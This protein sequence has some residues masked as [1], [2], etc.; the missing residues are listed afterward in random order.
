MR[1]DRSS[2]D[3]SSL[4]QRYGTLVEQTAAILFVVP[5]E[6]SYITGTTLPVAGV[7]LG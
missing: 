7:D 1:R 3:L 4:M 5:D 2:D 6:T